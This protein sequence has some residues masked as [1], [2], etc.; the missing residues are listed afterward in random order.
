MTATDWA[1][2][3][4]PAKLPRLHKTESLLLS[5]L[6]EV[7]HYPDA[8]FLVQAGVGTALERDLVSA[9]L[10]TQE[11][12]IA[13]PFEIESLGFTASSGDDPDI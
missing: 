12:N 5:R 3:L 1:W 9:G 7:L 2:T 13:I 6:Q 10:D 8:F 4:R 11:T